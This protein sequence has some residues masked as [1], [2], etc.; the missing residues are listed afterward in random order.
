MN[1]YMDIRETTINECPLSEIAKSM[2]NKSLDLRE[3]DRP[4][5]LDADNVKGCPI[6]GNGG[7]WSGER[8][9]SDWY[10]DKEALLPRYNPENITWGE[11]L[12]KHG[13]DHISFKE[14]EPDFS[15]IAQGTVEIDDFTDSRR[16]NFMQADEKLAEAR[17]CSPDE[18]KQWREENGYT[19]HEC[20]DCKTMQLVPSEIHNN[21][22]HTGGISEM[23]KTNEMDR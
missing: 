2:T 14:G 7:H 16:K 11:A 10:P 1:A 19:W 23:K 15:E 13:I 12:D 9:N 18:I 6:E 3:L 8:G 17:G 5:A 4:I 20:S 21:V 22:A